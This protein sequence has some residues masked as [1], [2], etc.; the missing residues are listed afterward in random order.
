MKINRD[1]VQKEP[2]AG[3]VLKILHSSCHRLL[4]GQ[5]EFQNENPPTLLFILLVHYT[6]RDI[7][8]NRSGSDL[9]SG[10]LWVRCS[11]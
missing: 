1:T 8:F 2:N 10:A 4:I 7:E 11:D 3:R 5:V 6:C 9:V